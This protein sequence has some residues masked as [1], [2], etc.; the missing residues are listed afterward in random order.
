MNNIRTTFCLAATLAF[1]T[2]TTAS[3]RVNDDSDDTSTW[4]VSM[5]SA[6]HGYVETID[7]Q[8]GASGITIQGENRGNDGLPKMER[9]LN[10]WN[11]INS[12]AAWYFHHP[13]AR[14]QTSMKYT[15]R[16]G[17]TARFLVSVVDPDTPSDTL[18]SKEL[19]LTGTGRE[20][21]V[22]ISDVTY[23]EAK[24]YR[25]RLQCLEGNSNLTNIRLFKFAS[26][27]KDQSY[28][29]N[30]LSSPSVHLSGWRSSQAPRGRIYDWAY[31]EV[32]IPTSSD[33]VGTYAMSL[34]VLKGYMG[35]QNDGRD[36]Q[37]NIIHDIIFSMWDS[38]SSD[39]DPNLPDYLRAGAVDANPE[40]NLYE[41]HNEGTGAGCRLNGYRWNPDTYVRFICNARPET[42]SYWTIDSLGDSI[43]HPQKNVLVTAWFDAQDGKG[44]QY[45]ATT[46][47]RN[48]EDLMDGWYS[49]LEN[50][51]WPT[52]QANRHAYFRNGFAHSY[53]TNR[54]YNFNQVGFGHTDGGNA[55][56]ARNDYQ[57]GAL[58]D[59]D[60]PTFYMQS[61][62]Y[63]THRES[64]GT[65]KRVGT[66]VVD[67]INLEALS[68]R[69]Q[70]A[71]DKEKRQKVEEAA[72]NNNLLDKTGWEVIYKSS[73]ETSGE[74]SNGRAQ[75][76]V[77]GDNNT[78]WHPK[79]Q[80]SPQATTPHTLI[81]DM[82]KEYSTA[83]FQISMSDGG[84][85]RH[86]KAY[87]FYGSTDNENW[88]LLKTDDN[89][90][91]DADI[92]VIFDQPQ[93]M[94]YFKLVINQ[95]HSNPWCRIN[96]ISIASEGVY[97]AGIHGVT[98]HAMAQGNLT[99]NGRNITL[100]A[101]DNVQ[102]NVSLFVYDG[103]GRV[104]S[105]INLKKQGTQFTGTLPVALPAGVY[106]YQAQW[107]NGFAVKKVV[108]E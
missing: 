81:V 78:Y 102:G 52:G 31:L 94:R 25:Y 54:W 27:S 37:G 83:G 88:T 89:A 48:T 92:R 26:P 44:W 20:D 9:T 93:T 106:L 24:Y 43:E 85:N 14:V 95:T 6:A 41:F 100:D 4:N 101:G 97:A 103:A 42:S 79:W 55:I 90:P 8:P 74:G 59:S 18:A 50:Y 45:L 72:F 104:L 73:E 39:V 68:A 28:V 82:K 32:M 7:G 86:I 67:S 80:G 107:N 11:N 69:V 22:V 5:A 51:N 64:S 33:V 34:G 16:N 61:G 17:R 58:T 12:A 40:A 66:E 38:G 36:A 29:A 98:K 15:I 91:N 87:E 70:Q 77:D 30:Y 108:A 53:R 105:R 10:S 84:G 47:I 63:T 2:A 1:C 65:I 21:S 99:V 35:I 62:A 60:Y 57:Q 46:R 71:V 23:K 96:E 19:T 56:G 13:A 49:F 76:I 75:Q 3:P